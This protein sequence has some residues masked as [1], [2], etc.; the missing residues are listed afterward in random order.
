MKGEDSK[1]HAGRFTIAS[2]SIWGHRVMG[3]DGKP[4]GKATRDYN[5]A[6]R[7]LDAAQREADS[8]A[9]RG[10]R[11]CMCCRRSFESAGIHNRLCPTCRTR[12]QDMPAAATM[13]TN[14]AKVR[15][16]ASL[17]SR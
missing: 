7:L 11:P 14:G 2:N 9:K 1:P 12:G 4:V 5:E 13:A 3:P 10:K 16:R 8:R 17:S 15:T 6:L